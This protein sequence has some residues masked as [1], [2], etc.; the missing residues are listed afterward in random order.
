MVTLLLIIGAGCSSKITPGGSASQSPEPFAAVSPS[1]SPESLAYTPGYQFEQPKS[2]DTIAVIKT[3]M[4]DIKVKLFP[5]EAP[6]AVENFITR[7]A[8]RLVSKRQGRYRPRLVDLSDRRESGYRH[9][10][11]LIRS[12]GDTRASPRF[13]STERDWLYPHL[14]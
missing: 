8:A 1:P 7:L 14:L 2:G 6:K 11:P 3:S 12:A 5:K 4:G 13:R 9:G 10:C